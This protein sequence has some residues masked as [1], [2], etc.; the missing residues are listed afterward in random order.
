[1]QLAFDIIAP[2]DCDLITTLALFQWTS[3]QDAPHI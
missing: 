1:M 3:E 2:F